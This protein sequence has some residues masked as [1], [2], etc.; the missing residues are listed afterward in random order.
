MKKED[1]IR[2]YIWLVDTL[3][4]AGSEGL[5]FKQINDK[6]VRNSYLSDG[7]DYPLRTFHNHRLEIENIFN[8]LILCDKS[9]NHYYIADNDELNNPMGVRKWLLDTLS[10]NNLLSESQAIRERILFENIPSGH[11]YLPAILEA[12]RDGN[13][14]VFDYRPFWLD[15]SIHYYDFEPYAVKVFRRRWYLL[16]K[17]ANYPLKLYSLDRMETIDFS[18]GTFEIPSTFDATSFFN[19]YFG[20]YVDDRVASQQILIR[21]DDAQAKY[22]RS[23]PLHHSQKELETRKE[24]SLF[25]YFL[26]PTID[27]KQEL[28]SMGA[29]IEIVEPSWLR[30]EFAETAR[31]MI[32]KNK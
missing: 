16:G 12:M 27:F 9:T 20:I 13:M 5:S 18:Q 6:W 32:K 30:K 24:N 22:L 31:L 7:K 11:A 28:L 26:R 1:N 4:L 29:A 10:V 25:S 8:I 19:S 2:R 23:L 3:D 21:A 17:Y 15:D 14:L